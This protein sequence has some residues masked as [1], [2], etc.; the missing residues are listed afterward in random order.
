MLGA[1]NQ[2]HGHI[3]GKSVERV[4]QAEKQLVQRPWGR[5]KLGAFMVQ[6]AGIGRCK[7]ET[8]HTEP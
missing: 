5:N 1:V 7:A 6:K 2:R 4:S 3:H 8:S